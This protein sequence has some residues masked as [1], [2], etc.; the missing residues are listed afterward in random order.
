M[1]PQK[2]NFFSSLTT[3]LSNSMDDLIITFHFISHQFYI[4]I[5]LCNIDLFTLCRKRRRKNCCQVMEIIQKKSVIRRDPKKKI[6]KTSFA[7]RCYYS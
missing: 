3:L 1:I 4:Y 6:T 2:R 5:F 7:V